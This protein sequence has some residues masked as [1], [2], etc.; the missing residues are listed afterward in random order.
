M[1]K[2]LHDQE[3]QDRL[4]R[5]QVDRDT[6][7]RGLGEFAEFELA[8]GGPDPHMRY[9][10]HMSMDSSYEERIWRAGVY[11]N[12]YNSPTAEV[13][14]QHWPW[15]AVSRSYGAREQFAGWLERH[16]KGLQLRRERRA[17]RT[18]VKLAK[19]FDS[20]IQFAQRVPQ[21]D[22]L[23][24]ALNPVQA[25]NTWWANTE[26]IYGFG[27]YARFKLIEYLSRYV[28]VNPVEMFD[29]RAAGGFSPRL[30]LA[31]L[32]GRDT[33]IQPYSNKPEHLSYSEYEATR[34]LEFLRTAYDLDVGF[35]RLEVFLCD[36]RQSYEGL[37]QYPGR[38]NDSELE[39]YYKVKDYWGSD[40]QSGL[41]DIRRKLVPVFC[42]GEHNSWTGVRKE[43]GTLFAETGVTW[44]DIQYHYDRQQGFKA[45]SRAQDTRDLAKATL[46]SRP[47]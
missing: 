15:Q 44:S 33:M 7:W 34:A 32:K 45:R 21:I 25:Y 9:V 17:V 41:F 8:A 6:L 12:V 27:R 23:I 47:S 24:P 11:V 30:T 10:G 3:F 39:Y 18:P 28:L 13:I 29:I 20:Y 46:H 37:R 1:G 38:S 5:L 35:Y 36:F 22:R 4:S 40:Y 31:D 19:A 26:S 43:L 42:R 16:W 14:W 2:T